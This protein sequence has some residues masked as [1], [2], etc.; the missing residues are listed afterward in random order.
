MAKLVA[1]TPC[2]GLLPKTIGGFELTE[3]DA[4]KIT[5]VMPFAG[6]DK[7]T[8]AALKDAIGLGFPAAGR[9]VGTGLRV[10]WCGKG[11]ALVMGGDCPDLQGAAV[12]DQSDAWAIV[13]IE[14]QGVEDVLARL[15]PVDL[16]RTQFKRGHTA[17]TL[18]G[19]M[20]GSVTRVGAAAFEVMV[21]R[22]MAATLVHD[23]TEAASGVAARAALTDG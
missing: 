18:I 1:L 7:A 10:V 2:T 5:S 23:L 22:S 21:M 8:S 9:M 11:Q 13:R 20:T 14:G 16:R 3:V 4:G 17:R 15:V 6:Q 19:H 12:V